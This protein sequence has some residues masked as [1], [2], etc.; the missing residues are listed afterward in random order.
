MKKIDLLSIAVHTGTYQEFMQQILTGAP[1]HSSRYACVANVHMLVE[2]HQ[3]AAFASIVQKAGVITPDGKPLAWALRLLY[4]VRQERVAG[5][6]LLPDLLSEAARQNIPVYF[7]GGSEAMLHDTEAYLHKHYPFLDIAG[8]HSPPFRALTNDEDEKVVAQINDS[9]A[10]L[11]FVVLGCPKQEKWMASMEGRVQAT[12]IGVGGALPVLIGTQK[13]AP[14][15]MQRA[16]LEWVYRLGQEP[17]RLLKRYAVT[18][19]IFL[20][21]LG[22]A[23]VRR[24]FNP[25]FSQR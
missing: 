7:Y 1:A 5:M 19:T 22:K 10:Q 11:V 18:N 2:A 25:S 24:L 3:D 13:R 14:A 17:K 23:Y 4:G 6:D 12:M 9:G 16:G 20:F 15:W 21:L 8:M